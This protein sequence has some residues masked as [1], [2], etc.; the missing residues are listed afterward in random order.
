MSPDPVPEAASDQPAREP[1]PADRY[2]DLVLKGGITSGVVY[3]RA[4]ARLA[5]KYRFRSIGGSSAGAIAAAVAAAA[6][7]QRRTTGS[8]AGFQ[9]LRALPDE[10]KAQVAPGQSKLL[11]LFQPH[12]DHRRLFD[13]LIGTL[14]QR[15]TASRWLTVVGGFARQY[16]PTLLAAALAAVALTWGGASWLAAA[17]AAVVIWLTLTGLWVWRDLSQ[18]VVPHDF[19]LCSGLTAPGQAQPALT[20]WLHALIQ[21]AAGLPP[22]SPPLTFGQLR[23]APGFP[24]PWMPP[25]PGDAA[26]R[27]IDLR[28]FSTNLSHGRPYVFPL[29]AGPG[30]AA[31]HRERLFFVPAELARTMPADVVAWMTRHSRPYAV[32]PGRETRD[33]PADAIAGLRELPAPDDFPVLLAARM[34]LSFPFLFCAIPLYAIDHDPA[35]ERPMRRCWFSDGGICTNFPMHLFDGLVPRWPTF[36]ITLED[37]VP[38]R[39]K[40]FLPTRYFEGFGEFWQ[41]FEPDRTPDGQPARPDAARALGTFIS[42]ILNAMQNWNDNTLLRMPGV[43]DRV[44]RVRLSAHEGG[45]NLNMEPEVIDEVARKGDI[46]AWKLLRRYVGPQAPGWIDHRFVRT[47][48]LLDM[49]RARLPD[50]R[51]TLAADQVGHAVGL[52]DMLAHYRQRRDAPPGFAQPMTPEQEQAI[53]RAVSALDDLSQAMDALARQMPDTGFS[54]VPRP[55]LRVRPP[56]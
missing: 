55:E 12:P 14:N 4:I 20:P 40:V 35:T 48:T 27:S 38:T 3:P 41:R 24:P 43:R 39:G 45:M 2:C 36:G 5:R 9:R 6:E 56:L 33:P 50:L 30:S 49:V 18:R 7:Y 51:S 19:G 11:S 22:G 23:H 28:M 17:L 21:E 54:A 10:L 42:A 44:A 26:P 47:M 53:V 31:W 25:R 46:A 29:D 37:E 15:S 13:V 32:P 8:D 16:W 34:S 52:H 1:P